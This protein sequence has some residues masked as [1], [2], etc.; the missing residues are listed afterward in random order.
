V[1]VADDDGVVVIERL[2]A[3]DVLASS[4]QREE[5]EAENR[6]RYVTGE[7][8]LDIYGMRSALEKKGLKYVDGDD[9]D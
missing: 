9:G 6:Q 4:K 1:I 5:K 3:A 8:G 2:K 7:L